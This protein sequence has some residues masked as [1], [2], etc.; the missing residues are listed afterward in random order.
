[1]RGAGLSHGGGYDGGSPGA[2]ELVRFAV[3]ANPVSGR[4][5]A[6]E[7]ARELAA[8]LHLAGHTVE[9]FLGHSPAE[10]ADFLRRSAD[11]A[12]RL[13]LVGGDGTLGFAVNAVADL[14]PV[15]LLPCG[16]ANLLAHHLH[17]PRDPVEAARVAEQG[18]VVRADLARVRLTGLDEEPIERWSALCVGF[19]PDGE[20]VRRI[21]EQRQGPIHIHDYA[22]ALADVATRWDAPPQRVL[23]NGADLGL[24]GYGIVS[25]VSVY[26]TGWWHLGPCALDDQRW[27]LFLLPELTLA[28]AA[29]LATTATWAGLERARGVTRTE[30]RRVRIEG[31]APSPVQVDGDFAGHTPVE[32]TLGDRHMRLIGPE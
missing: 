30:V 6:P 21:Q 8:H 1:M 19:G 5:R 20:I 23:A 11:W 18:L 15:A 26:G 3:L 28:N 29:R 14:P 10:A 31:D 9:S 27:E 16:T 32:L 2:A 25:G 24:H 12:D 22:G 7:A 17:L 13:A 4:G